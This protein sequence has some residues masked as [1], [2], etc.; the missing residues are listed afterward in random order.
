MGTLFHAEWFTI[1]FLEWIHSVS[2]TRFYLNRGGVP[3]FPAMLCL[4]SKGLRTFAWVFG[5]DAECALCLRIWASCIVVLSWH[6]CSEY[7]PGS[8]RTGVS[9]PLFFKGVW[10]SI[11]DEHI[12][13]FR[14]HG[15]RNVH[16]RWTTHLFS[17]FY[18]CLA[19][20]RH[21]QQWWSWNETAGGNSVE[22]V[23]IR[24]STRRVDILV[25]MFHFR[26]ILAHCINP[27]L[28]V[29]AMLN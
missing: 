25:R 2:Y 19:V 17:W 18:D 13:F 23:C 12:L 15:Q 8:R 4:L 11:W 3:P 28:F 9:R 6:L 24:V 22:G 26:R 1:P 16:Y 14:S 21:V 7:E 5:E 27:M 29:D 20:R 10:F